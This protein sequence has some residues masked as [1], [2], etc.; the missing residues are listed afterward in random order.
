[1]EP[2]RRAD[3]QFVFL[4]AQPEQGRLLCPQLRFHFAGDLPVYATADIY[5]DDEKS[6]RDLYGLQFTDMPWII[7]PAQDAE[8]LRQTVRTLW[9]GRSNMS[10]R[11]F[12]M[13]LD[14]YLLMPKLYGAGPVIE[15]IDGQTGR[16]VVGPDGV[17]HRGLVWARFNGGV[18]EPLAVPA[19]KD[20]ERE[21]ASPDLAA[22]R[23]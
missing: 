5:D 10:L 2:R 4:A 13:G 8:P 7:D 9:P 22:A 20:I 15:S 16:L 19:A 17:V 12:A 14:A 6:N 11:L 23:P 18:P 3:A 21:A 1:M